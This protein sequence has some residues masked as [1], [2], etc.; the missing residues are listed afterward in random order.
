[1]AAA[2]E[3]LIP[4]VYDSREEEKNAKI[5]EEAS[6]KFHLTTAESKNEL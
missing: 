5:Y 3:H 2:M 1:M 6:I 4:N